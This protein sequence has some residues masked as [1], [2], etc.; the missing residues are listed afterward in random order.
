[1]L[2][3]RALNFAAQKYAATVEKIPKSGKHLGTL[4]V[5]RVSFKTPRTARRI[6]AARRERQT[7][8]A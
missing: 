4:T 3:L 2:Q 1:V 6:K 7:P 5:R 8:A